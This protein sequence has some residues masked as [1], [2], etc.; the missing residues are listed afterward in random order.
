MGINVQNMREA[1]IAEANDFMWMST[2][3]ASPTE[4]GE[5]NCD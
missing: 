1:Q 2:R 3:D 5:S 4:Q